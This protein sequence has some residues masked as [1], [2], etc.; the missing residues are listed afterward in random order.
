MNIEDARIM[1][2][3]CGGTILNSNAYDVSCMR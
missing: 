1:K 2:E 3:T